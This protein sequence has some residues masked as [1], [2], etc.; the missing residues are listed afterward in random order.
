MR[1]RENG[2]RKRQ[3]ERGKQGVERKWSREREW[4]ESEIKRW[5]EKEN[6]FKKKEK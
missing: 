5:G 2:T 3:V 1:N 6:R 4:T